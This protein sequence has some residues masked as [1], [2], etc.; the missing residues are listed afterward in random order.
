MR[1]H[2][3]KLMVLLIAVAVFAGACDG[4]DVDG[5]D[6]A[7]PEP[8]Q[9][10][11]EAGEELALEAVVRRAVEDFEL[12]GAV[13][14]IRV[15]GEPSSTAAAGVADLESQ[16]ALVEEDRFRIYSV[17]KAVT[18]IVVLQL[19][20]EGALSLDDTLAD[21]LPAEVVGG[22]SNADRVT[23][24]QLLAHT[25][26]VPDHLDTVPPGAEL[27]PFIGEYL[28]QVES[29]EWR[30]YSPQELVDFSSQFDPP[31]S[32]GEGVAYSNTGYVLAGLVIETVTG[33]ELGEEM[34]ARVLEPLG[35]ADT[36]LESQTT[37]NDYVVGHQLVGDGAPVGLA[38][39]NS[40]FAWAA[41]GL[42]STVDDFG[43]LADAIF[44]GEL[45]SEESLAEMLTFR[46]GERPGIGY[47]MGLYLVDTPWGE[48]Q[49]VEGGAFGFTATGFRF[50]EDDTTVVGLFNVN[51]AQPAFEF[52]TAASRELV[53][54]R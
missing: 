50:P 15:D 29:G 44:T 14:Q 16:R 19:A 54:E 30:W 6:G 27:P 20:E 45:L 2:I 21:L 34:E 11:D 12:P 43:R 48:L 8:E 40:S 13:V 37:P 22:V 49:M 25:S 52:V 33:N 31:F 32:P 38:G 36:Y 42:I 53:S 35:L 4:A 10:V 39:S 7:D 28:G 5:S 18:A 17:T 24:R 9:E 3:K 1:N 41:G 26:G 23:V 46:T 47:G 51:D